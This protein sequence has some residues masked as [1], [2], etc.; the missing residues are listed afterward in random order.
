[1]PRQKYGR[2]ISVANYMVKIG[3]VD[4]IFSKCEGGEVEFKTGDYVDASDRTSKKVK[5]GVRSISDLILSGPYNP[6][7]FAPVEALLAQ[8]E[9]GQVQDVSVTVQ[10]IDNSVQQLPVGQPRNY[11]GC[12]LI[13]ITYPNPDL[14]GSDA[15]EVKI[16]LAPDSLAQTL[17]A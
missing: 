2:P 15:A 11:Q 10:A 8:L 16:T 5:S 7:D 13:K 9:S 4:Y 1:M 6:T 17:A 12:Q 14:S 3:S